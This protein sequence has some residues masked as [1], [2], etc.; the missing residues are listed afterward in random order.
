MTNPIYTQQLMDKYGTSWFKFD[1]VSGDVLDSKGN[2]VGIIS[3]SVTRTEGWDK[4]GKA[5]SFNNGQVSFSNF[6]IPF[7]NKTIRMKFKTTSA[8]DNQAL[9]GNYSSGTTN[10]NG[11]LIRYYGS[12]KQIILTYYLNTFSNSSTYE[13]AANI[14]QNTWY[15]LAIVF[16]NDNQKIITYVNGKQ[17]SSHSISSKENTPYT[18]NL[19]LGRGGFQNSAYYY[20][21][22]GEID[23][24]E[25][26]N[27]ALSRREI[28]FAD[29]TLL[30]SKGKT[31]SLKSTETPYETKMTSNNTPA[32]FVASASSIYS[33]S[34]PAYLAFNGTASTVNDCWASV[35]N[36]VAGW[37]QIDYG[38]SKI[39]NILTLTP[40]NDSS[41]VDSSPK[42]FNILASNDNIKFTTLLEVKNQVGWIAN[43]P[44]VFKFNNLKPY[45]YYRIEVISNNGRTYTAIGDITFSYK[46]NATNQT[47]NNNEQNFIKYGM[48]SVIPMEGIFSSKNYILQDTVSRN[49]DGLWITLLSRK[50][51]KFK[52]D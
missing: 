40:R 14:E 35:N 21:Y 1:E 41:T 22:Y 32:P 31:Y 26:Y 46:Y 51:V 11:V 18:G 29:K 44:R 49:S 12:T 23:E 19:Y 52:F 13:L 38:T 7:G 4:N 34:F 3:G 42:D 20:N 47:P 17:V 28:F 24:L 10:G 36:T 48:N 6:K 5:L 33:A 9:M 50:P 45:R 8:I 27:S 25:I 39:A 30:L 43:N 16:D 2:A 15:D 37:I